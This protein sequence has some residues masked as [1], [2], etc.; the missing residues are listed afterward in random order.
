MI[1]APNP[2]DWAV[3]TALGLESGLDCARWAAG[4]TAV[5]CPAADGGA[6]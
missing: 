1:P 6:R 4:F 5:L 2:R 3:A